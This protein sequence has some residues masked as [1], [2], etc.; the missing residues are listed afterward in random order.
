MVWEAGCHIG[1]QGDGASFAPP[2]A[3]PALVLEEA[4][5]N[6]LIKVIALLQILLDRR[7][8]KTLSGARGAARSASS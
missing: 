7:Q 4:P 5:S 1:L 2:K 3:K 6:P 8:A